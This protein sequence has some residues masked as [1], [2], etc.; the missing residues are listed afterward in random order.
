MSDCDTKGDVQTQ[1][2]DS[3]IPMAFFTELKE[4]HKSHRETKCMDSKAIL[5]TYGWSCH[6]QS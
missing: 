5:T 4:N 1:N 3:E 6:T 2:N